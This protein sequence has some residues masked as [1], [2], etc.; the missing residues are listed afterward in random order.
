M[1]FNQERTYDFFFVGKI[2]RIVFPIENCSNKSILT[3]IR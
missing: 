1:K 2:Q 3:V